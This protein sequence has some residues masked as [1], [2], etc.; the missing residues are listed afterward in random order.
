MNHDG[1]DGVFCRRFFHLENDREN[2]LSP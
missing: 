1:T 2:E